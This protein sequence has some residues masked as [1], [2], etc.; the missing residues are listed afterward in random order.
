MLNDVQRAIGDVERE[1]LT[2]KGQARIMVLKARQGGVSTDQQGRALHQIWS[3]RGFDALTLAHTKEDTEKLFGITTR[4]IEHFPPAL[5]PRL[6]EKGT[7]EVSFPGRDARLYTG[8]AGS[9]RTGRGLTI[10]RFHGSEFA[11]W[12]DPVALLG[13]VT[14]ALVPQGSI[15]VLETT[16]SGFDSPAHNF[17]REAA[18]RGYRAVFYPWWLCDRAN[19][20]LPLFAYDELGALTDEEQLLLTAHGL[21]LEQLKWRRAKIA[22]LTRTL[23]LQEYAEDPES[24]W[25]AVGGMFFD[26]QQ[27]KALMLAAP[28]PRSVEL[29]GALQLYD[30][31]TNERVIIGADTAEGTGGDRST[32]TARTR[33]TWKLRATFEDPNITPREFAALLNTWGRRLAVGGTPAFLVVEKNAHGI[34]VLRHLVDDHQYPLAAIYHR[35][36]HDQSQREQS[37]RIGWATT[38]E[39]KPLMLDAG[40]ELVT[41]AVERVAGNPSK[42]ALRDAF[43]VRRGADGRYDLNGRDMLVSEMLAWLGRSAPVGVWGTG[44]YR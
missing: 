7:T 6:G 33:T 23:F 28:E 13:S 41:A 40:R 5:L 26:A 1:E 32:F 44:T 22:E 43:A 24:C 4:A 30:A 18:A 42:A 21:D 39:S 38:A 10:K 16:A 2:T 12:G 29:N 36:A 15:V 25:A 11:F 19:Y 35:V 17:W 31:P 3:E 34:T 37:G 27:I 9:K 14:P 20:R 8:T